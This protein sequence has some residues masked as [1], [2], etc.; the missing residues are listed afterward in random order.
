MFVPPV[1]DPVRRAACLADPVLFLKTYNPKGPKGFTSDFAIHHLQMIKA[2]HERAISGGDK[3]VAAPRGDGKTSVATWM[4]I[5]IILAELVRSVVIVGATRKLSQRIFKDIK[6]AFSWNDLLAA[7]FPEIAACVRE[8]DGAPQRAAKQHVDGQPTR[9]V[10]TQDELELP[11]VPGS[12]Y[13]GCRIAYYGLDSAIRG[14][15]FEFALIDDPETR[16]VA[17]NEESNRKIEEMIDSDIAGLAYPNST[18]SRV[19]LT[20]VQNRRCYSYRVTDPKIKPAFAGERYGMLSKW[21]ERRDMWDEYIA[22]R[23]AGQASGDKD[24]LEA[25]SWFLENREEME[26]GSAVTNPNRFNH[27]INADGV[28]VE[29]CALQAFFNRV[30][31]WGLPRVLA[32]LQNDPEEEETEQTL[33]LTAG[34][35]Q[36]RLSGLARHE[37]PK[38]DCKIAVGI[39]IGKY[40]S[41]WVKIAFHGSAIGSIIDYGVMENPGMNTATDP[42]AVQVSLL[43][44]L[45]NWADEIQAENPPDIVFVDSG[46]Y[47]DAVY[48]FTRRVGGVFKPSKGNDGRMQFNRPA[49]DVEGVRYFRECRADWQKRENLWLFHVNS[50]YW[51]L[52]VQQRFM[53]ETF[54][55]GHMRN[56]GTL[57]L[58]VASNAKE[59]HSYSQHIIAEE[60]QELFVEGKGLQ[61]KWEVKSKNNHWLDATALAC[62]AADVMGIRTIPRQSVQQPAKSSQ[63]PAKPQQPKVQPQPNRFR[64]RSGGWVPR[65]R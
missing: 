62:C 57:A 14:G 42:Q 46:D 23:Q 43:S 29:V 28:A 64:Q 54:D 63:S 59:H 8:L 36:K 26:R 60:W 5:Y 11:H 20:T 33:G 47:T 35:V 9:I 6:H 21:P 50:T 27:R 61:R 12:P 55:D 30:T 22:R 4:V 53:V 25:L 52:A 17:F 32:E 15:R 51:K 2:I 13:G 44:S 31:D 39:D 56:D 58:F 65:R 40:S 3:A 16:E 49:G 41:H 24:G 45:L 38:V 48:E 1:A 10:W 7:D 19:I 34:I 37:L 18:I